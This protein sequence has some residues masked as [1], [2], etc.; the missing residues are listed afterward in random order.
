MPATPS[1]S[2]RIQRG[3]AV[4]VRSGRMPA[5]FVLAGGILL[6]YGFLIS[7]DFLV[8]SVVVRGTSIGD[9]AE[10]EITADA[11]GEPI[12]TIDASESAARVAAL[13]YVE[14]VTVSTRFPDEVVITV[15][16]SVPADQWPVGARV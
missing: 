14:R 15:D 4:L 12:F 6:L 11:I 1:R 5:F 10:V 2:A 7:G 13:P 8:G 16:E 3:L 9:P